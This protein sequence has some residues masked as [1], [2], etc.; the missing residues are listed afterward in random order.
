VRTIKQAGSRYALVIAGLAAS[1]AIASSAGADEVK[2]QHYLPSRWNTVSPGVYGAEYPPVLKIASGD[3]VK[4]DIAN[5]SGIRNGDPRK[6]FVDNNISLDLPV[7]KDLIEIQEKTRPHPKGLR[8]ALLTG[9][10]YIEGAE[11]GDMLEVRVHDVRFRAPYGVNSTSPGGGHPL[12]DVVPR[13]WTHKFDIDVERNVAL[14]KPG[15]IELP[16]APFMGQMG[17]AP[18]PDAGSFGAGP[19]TPLHG[20]NFDLQELS[21]GGT[22]FLPVNVPGALFFTGNGHALQGNGEITN[23]SLEVSLTGYF[24]F[25]V[26]KNHPLKM[27]RVETPTHY[28]FLGMHNSLD[29]AVRQATFETVEFVQKKE[30]LDFYDAYAL[31]SAAV[32]FTV[33]RALLPAQMVYSFL[34]KHV[35]SDN[36]PYWYQGPVP[37]KY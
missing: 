19:P 35:F 20:G 22:L 7:V 4:I 31:T 11:P 21:R 12:G 28:I 24:E 27:P 15:E 5:T 2:Y 37:T 30:R 23:P 14:F 3:V 36:A 9:P 34:P 33:A 16:L 6:F 1:V 29:E 8:G 13:P 25:I 18:P 10:V 17:V 32:D 26:H